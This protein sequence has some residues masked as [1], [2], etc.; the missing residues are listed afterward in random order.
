MKEKLYKILIIASVLVVLFFETGILV[1]IFISKNF[2]FVIFIAALMAILSLG[3][4]V[5]LCFP[6]ISGAVSPLHALVKK[7]KDYC[8]EGLIGK[9]AGEFAYLDRAYSE[10]INA[11]MVTPWR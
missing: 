1:S 4:V 11:Q 8:G 3:T 2:T 7:V 9:E 6:L 5:L 10:M